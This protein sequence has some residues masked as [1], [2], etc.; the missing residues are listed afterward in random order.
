MG[1]NSGRG[2]C[3]VFDQ[4]EQI[5]LIIFSMPNGLYASGFYLPDVFN[6]NAHKDIKIF[7]DS[8]RYSEIECFH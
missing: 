4:L 7:G 8:F 6:T 5:S 3:S 2:F 1:K